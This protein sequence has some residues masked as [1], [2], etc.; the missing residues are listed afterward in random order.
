[1]NPTDHLILD[2]PVGSSATVFVILKLVRTI[3]SSQNLNNICDLIVGAIRLLEI[4]KMPFSSLLLPT[5]YEYLFFK[6]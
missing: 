5:A 1:M 3:Y 6:N 2:L 4:Q